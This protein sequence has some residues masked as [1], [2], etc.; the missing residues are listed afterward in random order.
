[1]PPSSYL[2]V[3]GENQ[4]RP[5][6]FFQ[7]TGPV[8]KGCREAVCVKAVPWRSH[9]IVRQ[10]VNLLLDRAWIFFGESHRKQVITVSTLEKL[11]YPTEFKGLQPI[12]C[13]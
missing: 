2:V 12:R 1:M 4:N 5:P 11:L 6:Y 10:P 8:H 3:E 9:Q 13:R 7:I